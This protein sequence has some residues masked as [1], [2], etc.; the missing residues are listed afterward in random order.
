M[1]RRLA[2]AL[3]ALSILLVLAAPV[4]A[5]G[6]AEVRP[7]AATTTEPPIEGQPIE[8]GFTVLQHGKT[9]AGWVTPTVHV[10][11]L[12][13]GT[14]LE[15][16]AVKVGDEG[17]FVASLTPS[18]AGY[19]SWVVDFPE[20]ATDPVPVTLAVHSVGGAAPVFDPTVA[21][22]AVVRAKDEVRSEIYATVYEEVDRINGRLALQ[23][24]IS[25]RLT[26][27]VDAITKERDALSV[28]LAEGGVTSISLLAGLVL[29]AVL[30][31]GTAG[32]AMHWLGRR[33]SPREIEVG[34][35]AAPRGV[36]PA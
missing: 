23:Q 4:A 17:H 5:G 33:S 22:S 27:Q 32:F 11:D 24:S 28:Q 9:P 35:S 19:L 8:I 30:A 21:V 10:T 29:V 25:E 36:D 2:A 14:T 31:G 6:W 1:T 34:F 20:L 3:A 13:T 18:H 16:A 26:T 7:D 15:I 12:T